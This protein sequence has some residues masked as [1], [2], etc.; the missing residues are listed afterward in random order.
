MQ[1][2]IGRV[3]YD[4]ETA[5]LIV[6]KTY[7]YYGDPAGYEEILFKT[8]QVTT[9]C[10]PTAASS[11]STPPRASR[12]SRQRTLSSLSQKTHKLY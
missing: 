12:D 10:T 5:T 8:P 11:P 7:G 1:K 6:K 4:T 9:L 2:K 3:I